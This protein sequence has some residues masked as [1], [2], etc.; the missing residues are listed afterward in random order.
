MQNLHISLTL[1]LRSFLLFLPYFEF[2][3]LA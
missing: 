3:F 2:G 1:N